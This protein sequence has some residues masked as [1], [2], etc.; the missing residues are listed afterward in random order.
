M[1]RTK[2]RNTIQGSKTEYKGFKF[3]RLPENWEVFEIFS[4]EFFWFLASLY[5]FF[6]SWH[7]GSWFFCIKDLI[8]KKAPCYGGLQRIR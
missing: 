7:L 3:Q 1:P 6:G 8:Q 4:L 2:E 5:S